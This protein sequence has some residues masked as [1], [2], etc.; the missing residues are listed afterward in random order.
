M[1]KKG[2]SDELFLGAKDSQVLAVVAGIWEKNGSRKL[3]VIAGRGGGSP[4][5][6]EMSGERK[7]EERPLLSLYFFPPLLSPCKDEGRMRNEFMPKKRE[8]EREDGGG[9]I[10]YAGGGGGM[11]HAGNTS[12]YVYRILYVHKRELGGWGGNIYSPLMRFFFPS[13]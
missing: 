12:W 1:S 8:R 2:K 10:E 4:A 5:H 6:K 13:L 7:E 3:S 9:K 11:M